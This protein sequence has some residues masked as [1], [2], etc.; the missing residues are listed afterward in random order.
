MKK[1]KILNAASIAVVI[2]ILVLF[3]I[4]SPTFRGILSDY[5]FP[6]I[7][8]KADSTPVHTAFVHII[9]VGQGDSILIREADTCVLIDTGPNSAEDS[10]ISYLRAADVDKLDLLV[11]THPHEDHMGCADRVL[12]EYTVDTVLMPDCTSN[13]KFFEYFLDAV[14][15]TGTQIVIP[16]RGDKFTLDDLDFTLLAPGNGEYEETNDY[17]IV[18]KVVHKNTAFMF[19][20]D[21]EALSEREILDYFGANFLKSDLLKA[22]HHG[23]TTSNTEEFVSAVSP[24]YAVFSCGY[25]NSYGHPHREVRELFE[26]LGIE[27]TRTD[28]DGSVVYVSDGDKVTLK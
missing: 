12:R 25:D 1:R 7:F 5:G 6:D 16:E 2:V 20:G 26:E 19:T 28:Y 3:Y 10:L 24:K 13:A 8:R 11:L 4:F 17:S 23:S 27:Y 18:L 22:G 9:D 14:E 15:D 21:A